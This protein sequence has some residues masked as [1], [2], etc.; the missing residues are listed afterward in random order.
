MLKKISF[1]ILGII[2]IYSAV[3][4]AIKAGI[5][6]MP[7]DAAIAT[8][9]D[10][11]NIKVGTIS[12]LF[13]GS[14]FIGQI[15][16]EK[17]DFQKTEFLQILYITLGGSVLNFFLYTVLQNITFSFYPVRLVV[18]ILAFIVSAFGCTLVLET[19]LMRTP[20]EGC[21]QMMADRSRSGITMG[22]LRQIID[23]LLVV[24]AVVLTLI[25]GTD[26][27][28]REGTVIAALIFGPA[29]DFWKKTVFSK[30]KI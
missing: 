1:T 28:L 17:K 16:M 22:K 21:I 3:A 24:L 8:I 10:V 4:F 30:I 23:I 26:W 18:C 13:H 15:L 19:H 5:G 2:L 11:V 25:F 29:M 6:V 12:M 7:V 20:M 27:T 9:A 14:F